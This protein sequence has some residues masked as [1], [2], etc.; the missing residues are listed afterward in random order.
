MI[1]GKTIAVV[2]PAY[3]EEN[4]IG[5]VIE[6]M[7]DFVDRIIIVNDCSKDQTAKVVLDYITSNNQ[8]SI[9]IP[10][11][12]QEIAPTFF[13]RADIVA[14]EMYKEESVL[15]PPHEIVNGTDT[16]RIILINNLVNSHVGGAIAVGY[17]WCRDHNIDCTAV[18]AGDAQMDPDELESICLPV[19]DEGIDYVKGNRLRH[20][21]A[22]RMIPPKRYFG[23][24]VLSAMTKVASGYW[25]VSDTQTGYTAIS[26]GALD[27]IELQKIYHTYGMPN[28]MLIRLN[29]AGC[30]LREIPIKPV[31]AVGE[32]SKMKIRKVV[33]RVSW[34]LF[35][36]FFKRIYIKYFVNDFHP[37]CVFYSLGMLAGIIAVILLVVIASALISRIPVTS[38][39]FSG[40]VAAMIAQ[41]LFL[42]FGMWMD[43]YDNEKL[44]R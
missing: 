11:R 29:I 24:S 44:Q 42:G 13:N 40:F 3:N 4:Q 36:G 27:L 28:D 6:T 31:Y 25:R 39:T 15:L 16:Q 14:M 38:G 23:N 37:I 26:L 41:L 32:Q 22:K 43:V 10:K 17:L 7:P 8:E 2:V 19:I 5:I 35:K 20:K 34:L 30:T 1:H 12:E 18:M 33:P 9:F 21:A